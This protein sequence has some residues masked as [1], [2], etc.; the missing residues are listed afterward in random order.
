MASDPFDLNLKELAAGLLVTPS[1]LE[2]LRPEDAARVVDVMQPRWFP[3]GSVVVQEGDADDCDYM[4]LLLE[5]ELSV[6]SHFST[7]DDDMVVRLMGP[8]SLIGE[9]GL[10]DGAPRSASCVAHTD[11]FAAELRRDDFLRLIHEQPDV[12]V[13]LLLAISKRIADH[14]RDA[15]RKLKLLSTMNRALSDTLASPADEDVDSGDTP[16]AFTRT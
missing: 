14:L 3:A 13:R 6:E 16:D 1:A 5:G 10:L 12:G 11:L 8:G 9:M 7:G 15:T 4:L 2:E